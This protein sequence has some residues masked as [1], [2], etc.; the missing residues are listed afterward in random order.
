MKSNTDLPTQPTDLPAPLSDQP[1]TGRPQATARAAWHR[2][3]LTRIE[4]K[5]TMLGS[6]PVSDG[7]TLDLG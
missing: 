1:T 3:T 7:E 2:Q 6:F 5:R 4:I